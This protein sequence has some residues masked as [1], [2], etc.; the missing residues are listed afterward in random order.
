MGRKDLKRAKND[1]YGFSAEVQCSLTI[2]P[3]AQ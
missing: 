2:V 3:F 1:Y